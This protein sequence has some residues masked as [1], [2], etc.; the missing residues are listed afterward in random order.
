MYTSQFSA[1]SR[2]STLCRGPGETERKGPAPRS[3]GFGALMADKCAGSARERPSAL[4]PDDTHN[5]ATTNKGER[6]YRVSRSAA[7]MNQSQSIQCLSAVR[8]F[9]QS[10]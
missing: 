6:R 9:C 7:R 3:I 2:D 8:F 5:P 10:R 4:T 1:L